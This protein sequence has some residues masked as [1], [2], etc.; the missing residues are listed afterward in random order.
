MAARGF[1]GFYTLSKYLCGLWRG[2]AAGVVN[3]IWGGGEF[4]S[5][6]LSWGRS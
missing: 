5:E 6:L 2:R 3:V 4:W 1:C